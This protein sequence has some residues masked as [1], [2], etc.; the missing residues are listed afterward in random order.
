MWLSIW[1]G[2]AGEQLNDVLAFC[3]SEA[4]GC[5][6][7]YRDVSPSRSVAAV[8]QRADLRGGLVFEVQ[9]HALNAHMTSAWQRDGRRSGVSNPAGRCSHHIAHKKLDGGR[10]WSV[11]DVGHGVAFGGDVA[12]VDLLGLDLDLW[13]GAHVDIF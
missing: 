5:F 7:R 8:A 3:I 11:V 6:F 10:T 2:R 4:L 9:L 1:G 12:H 13:G